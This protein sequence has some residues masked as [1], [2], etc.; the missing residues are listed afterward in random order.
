M[1]IVGLG[2]RELIV[3]QTPALFLPF[4]YRQRRAYCFFGFLEIDNPSMVF[5]RLLISAQITSNRPTPFY[6]DLVKEIAIRQGGF[7]FF[8]PFSSLYGS[9]GSC[10]FEVARLSNI[11]GTSDS[12]TSVSLSLE[13]DDD[14]FVQSWRN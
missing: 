3:G 7:S 14:V 9:N 8:Y 1:A 5:S 12:E 4:N 6:G 2:V 10:S 13:Y 11:R